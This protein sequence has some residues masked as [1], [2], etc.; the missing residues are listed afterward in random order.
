MNRLL[1]L[2]LILI[3]QMLVVLL[4]LNG[5]FL[6]C[7]GLMDNGFGFGSGWFTK[8]TGWGTF[9]QEQG[10]GNEN[11]ATEDLAQSS[12]AAI[13]GTFVTGFTSITGPNVASVVSFKPSGGGATT[14]NNNISLLGTGC[15]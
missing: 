3:L 4:L 6:V 7:V 15:Q 2:M 12:A 5:A 9:N 10:G 8:G 13:T 1:V 14:C 11:M